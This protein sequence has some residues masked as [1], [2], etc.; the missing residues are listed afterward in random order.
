M[1]P[2]VIRRLKRIA[3]AKLA[4]IVA[5]IYGLGALLFSPLYLGL[6]FAA[7][8]PRLHGEFSWLVLAV[9][10]LAVLVAVPLF[11]ALFGYLVGAIGAW[12][13]NFSAARIGGI[14][15]EVE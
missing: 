3:P 10:G 2:P 12:L 6:I 8:S 13:Y 11:Y 4:R 1:N 9:M 14:E 15:F 7:N 5:F